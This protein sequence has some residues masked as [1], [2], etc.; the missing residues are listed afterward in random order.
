MKTLHYTLQGID[1]TI[2]YETTTIPSHMMEPID[3]TNHTFSTTYDF[4]PLL[5]LLRAWIEHA[6]K[7]NITYWAVDG[8]LLGCLRHQGIIPWDNDIDFCIKYNQYE[9]IR[10]TDFGEYEVI[11]VMYGFMFRRR[12]T[13]KPFI[14]LFAYE[15][16]PGTD[17]MANCLPVHPVTQELTFYSK[18]G[19]LMVFRPEDL[20]EMS[21]VPFEDM[22]LPVPQHAL[23]T[24]QRVYGDDVMTHLYYDNHVESL[25]AGIGLELGLKIPHHHIMYTNYILGLHDNIP[26]Y[27]LDALICKILHHIG[28]RHHEGNM[29]DIIKSISHIVG[30]TQPFLRHHLTKWM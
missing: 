12:G 8:T 25:H 29:D 15:I 23:E 11:E 4:A 22:E 3:T 20:V 9:K 1:H 27:N 5:S 26:E 16:E 17:M 24:V 10:G 18:I 2:P 14:D 21:V 7:H 6:T 13:I 30:L 19:N 28:M